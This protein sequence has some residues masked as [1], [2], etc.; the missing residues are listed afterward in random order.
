MEDQNADKIL[1]GQGSFAGWD[2]EISDIHGRKVYKEIASV[3]D[4]TIDVNVSNLNSGVYFIS[5]IT[6]NHKSTKKFVK[7]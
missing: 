1:V 4:E 2:F 5:L 6:N 3:V 7:K